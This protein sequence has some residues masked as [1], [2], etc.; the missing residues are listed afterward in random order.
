MNVSALVRLA[1]AFLTLAAVALAADGARAQGMLSSKHNLSSTGPG[2]IRAVSE[3]QVCVFCH[4]PHNANPA[5]P[6]W[7]RDLSGATYTPYASATLNFT[8]AGDWR[9]NGYSRLCLSCH[10][11]TIAIGKVHNLWGQS[12]TINVQNTGPGGVI[13]SG[14]TLVGTDLGNDHPISFVFNSALSAA[15][16]ELVNP[17]T[18]TGV[19]RLYEGETPGVRDSVQCTTCHDPHATVNPK[20]L[21]KSFGGR[22]DN[23]CL[24]CH[25]KPGWT[26]SSHESATT[27]F[28]QG[29]PVA[30]FSCG[31]C[32][33]PHTDQGAPR[34]L[35]GAAGAT[36]PAIEQTCYRCHT[37]TT[38]GGI[39]F[40]LETQF[41]KTGSLHRITSYSGHEPVF[42]TSGPPETVENT[43]QHVECTDCHNPHRVRERGTAGTG[44]VFEGMRGI[45]LD[46]TVRSDVT[47]DDNL[48]EYEIC[49]RCHGDTVSQVVGATVVGQGSGGSALGTIP[50]ANKRLDFQTTNSS[51]HPVPAAGRSRKRALNEQLAAGTSGN[52]SPLG[53]GSQIKCTDCHNNDHYRR[54]NGFSGVVS[55][56]PRDETQP[57]GPH[58]ST[59]RNLLRTQQWN[60]L[61]GPTKP[62]TDAEVE[63]N[64]N[65]CFQCHDRQRFLNQRT[66]DNPRAW[67]NFFQG[68]GNDN[69]HRLHLVDRADKAQ[70]VCRS[71]HYNIHSN[72]QASNTTYR[73]CTGSPSETCTNSSTPPQLITGWSTALV[74]FH[75]SIRGISGSPD[76]SRPVFR[77]NTTTRQRA[78]WLQCHTPTGG[79]GGATM[80]GSDGTK[81]RYTPP[82]DGDTV[83]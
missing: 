40:D 14:S 52:P 77:I 79:T 34:L 41:A 23:L 62:R 83:L 24:T 44:G 12:T 76:P 75:P 46:R 25:V 33:S 2:T 74:N 16:G 19:V 17:T 31:A 15:D 32:H 49:L 27:K 8:Y 57:K 9:P 72:A 6:L 26:N 10:D 5:S 21:K 35:R 51:Y 67:T 56:W 53:I 18:L 63:T 4:T 64:F 65:L 45:K 11:G 22:V 42:T 73:I 47:V 68:G 60:N 13:P 28:F 20:F 43:S 80:D 38:E 81:F 37:S 55:Q 36:Q 58:G 69:L 29:T 3:T 7:N 1:L 66:D 78:C 82:A 54:Q 48:F 39:T 50:T 71:C 59:Y 70:P 30:E 61:P